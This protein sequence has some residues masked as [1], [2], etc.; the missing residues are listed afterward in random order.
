MVDKSHTP[1]LKPVRLVAKGNKLLHGLEL[2]HEEIA[3]R[4]TTQSQ[5]FEPYCTQAVGRRSESLLVVPS[6]PT[7][8]SYH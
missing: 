2:L 4:P 3:R 7:S 1:L 6:P 5:G 8:C